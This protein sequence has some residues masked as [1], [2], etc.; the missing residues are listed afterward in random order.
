MCV[1]DSQH[2]GTKEELGDQKNNGQN[3]SMYFQQIIYVGWG[4]I[5]VKDIR[6]ENVELLHLN[7]G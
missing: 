7:I 4:I 6:W 2:N 1:D 3:A 5:S